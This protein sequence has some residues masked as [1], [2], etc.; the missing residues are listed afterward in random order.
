MSFRRNVFYTKCPL[1]EMRGSRNFSQGGGGV[2]QILRRG[3][4]EN[5]NMTKIKNLAIPG[6][7]GGGEFL[8]G[9]RQKNYFQVKI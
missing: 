9:G 3:L 8:Y 2:V 1:D 5:F 6:V 7:G 4:T